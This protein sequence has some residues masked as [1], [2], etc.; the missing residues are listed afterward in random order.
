[1]SQIEN[2]QSPDIKKSLEH[3]RLAGRP[4]LYTLL[5]LS[6]GPILAQITGALKGIITTIWI[7][8]SIGDKGLSA[9][10]TIGVYDGISRA[11]GFYI[12]ASGSSR[13]SQ[14]Y[15]E[16]KEEEASQVFADLLRVCII[17]GILVPAILSPTIEPICRWFGAKDDL[18]PMC[19]EY[20]LPINIATFSTIMFIGLGGCLQGEGRSIFYSILNI[21]TLVVN[22]AVLDPILLL[23]FKTGIWGASCGQVSSEAISAFLILYLYFSGKFGVKVKFRYLLR[24]FSPHTFPALKVGLSQLI[25][26]LSSLVPSLL[27]RKLF[28]MAVKEEFNDAM[29]GFNTIVRVFI[30]VNSLLIAFA[31]GFLPPASYANA[32]RLYHRWFH[33]V[34]HLLWLTF[35]WGTFC[36]IITFSLAKQISLLFSSTPGYLKYAVPMIK[37]SNALNILCPGRFDAVSILQSLQ[38]G[39]YSTILSVSTN[40]VSIVGFSFLLYYCYKSDGAKIMWCYSLANGFGFIVS[41]IAISFPVRKLYLKMKEQ[42]NQQQIQND[43]N[44]DKKLD[45]FSEEENIEDISKSEDN[46]NHENSSNNENNSNNE[47]NSKNEDNS[48]DE[49]SSN[50]ENESENNNIADQKD[51]TNIDEDL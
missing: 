19:K 23:G 14:L 46:S 30:F 8:H 39:I 50:N 3:Y 33:L 22:M 44:E 6:L 49:N 1:M 21:I 37:N 34:F 4:P 9:V 2:S 17:F 40:L 18:I 25:S 27:V 38:M 13:I 26:N 29:S 15:G 20:M 7:S 36:F 5:Y 31:M 42:E 16:H 41:L 12:A 28:G 47:K 24:K 51:S 45:D 43:Q 11:F 35:A 10:S 48:K 32:S